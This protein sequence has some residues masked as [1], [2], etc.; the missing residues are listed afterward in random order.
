[1]Q[2]L[3]FLSLKTFLRRAARAPAFDTSR[4]AHTWT[5]IWFTEEDRFVTAI[6]VVR[7]VSGVDGR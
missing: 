7:K 3:D 2:S 5:S 1:M 6:L 4:R